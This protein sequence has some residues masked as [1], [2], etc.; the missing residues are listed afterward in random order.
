MRYDNSLL[1]RA[2]SQNYT[3]LRRAMGQKQP[4]LKNRTNKKG[5][6]LGHARIK[7]EMCLSLGNSSKKALSI[8]KNMEVIS[9]VASE[10]SCQLS[11]GLAMGDVILG[12]GGDG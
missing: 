4:N 7:S 5:E 1:A 6:G 8:L 10:R 12:I 3:S 11:H 2:L 9:A